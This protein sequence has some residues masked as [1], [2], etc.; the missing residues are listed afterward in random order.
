[1]KIFLTGSPGSGKTTALLKIY[2]TLKLYGYKVGGFITQEY[3][4]K[5]R[6]LGFKILALDT[7]EIGWLA[8]V[9]IKNGPKIG[10][11]GVNIKDLDEIGVAALKRAMQSSDIVII[12]EVGPMELVSDKFRDALEELLNTDKTAIISVHYKISSRLNKEFKI[13]DESILFMI[14]EKN[15]EAMPLVIWERIRRRGSGNVDKCGHF[16]SPS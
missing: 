3:R 9:N 8:N 10:R 13:D 7:Q 1:M 6:R 12:D 11:Y 14:T 4:E 5:G 2:E 15:R 16:P